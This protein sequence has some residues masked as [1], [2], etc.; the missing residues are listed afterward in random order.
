M[1][2]YESSAIRHLADATQLKSLGKIDNAGH[3]IGFAAEC[4]IKHHLSTIHPKQKSPHGHFPD[5]LI[6]AR[7]HLNQ[8]SSMFEYIRQNI[9]ANWDVEHRYFV[10]GTTSEANLSMWIKQ[11]RR[12]FATANI[13]ERL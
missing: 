6:T 9:M 11:T 7:K 13:K 5:F 4:A 3:L 1:E 12:V 2:D 8:R 10:T